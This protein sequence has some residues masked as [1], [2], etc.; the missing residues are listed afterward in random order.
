MADALTIFFKH[1]MLYRKGTERDQG[2]PHIKPGLNRAKH[3]YV[4]GSVQIM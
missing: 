4:R 1:L 2:G 3:S